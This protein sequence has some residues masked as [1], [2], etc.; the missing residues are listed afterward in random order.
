MLEM[1]RKLRKTEDKR[2]NQIEMLRLIA[3]LR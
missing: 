3:E 2:T 1:K